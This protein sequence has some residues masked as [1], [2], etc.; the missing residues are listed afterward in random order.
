M[1]TIHLKD[2]NVHRKD[3]VHG[4]IPARYKFCPLS[5]SVHDLQV[6]SDFV[7]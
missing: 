5:Y 4:R 7:L 3:V 1:P 6:K 2:D